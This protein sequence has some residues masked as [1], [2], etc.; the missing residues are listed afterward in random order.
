MSHHLSHIIPTRC[1]KLDSRVTIFIIKDMKKYLLIACIIFLTSNFASAQTSAEG[2]ILSRIAQLSSDNLRSY[3]DPLMTSLGVALGTGIFYTAR[4]H[5]AFG[6]D[7]GLRVMQVRIPSSARF[8][9][10]TV[11]ACSLANGG[12]DCYDILVENASTIFGPEEATVVPTSGNALAIP[13]VF[14][15]GLDVNNLPFVMPQINVGFPFGL[16]LGF[17]YLPLAMTFPL[18]REKNVSFIR[19]GAKL[20]FNKLPY[21]NRI[22][23]PM[24]LAIGGFYQIGHVQGDDQVATMN[25]ALWNLQILASKRIG[26]G[27]LLA[28]EPFLAG[29][30][31]GTSFNFRYD[32]QKVLPDTIGGIPTDSIIVIEPIDIDYYQQNRF[33]AIIGMSLYVG[34]IFFHYDYNAVTYRTHNLML[35]ITVR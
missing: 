33:R 22:N 20:G 17:G 10:A 11:V 16:E 24:D 31:E 6:F 3:A 13:P 35:G 2:S 23:L 30:I 4:S 15:G 18:D 27:W 21:L 26:T 8:F 19:L 25:M 14:P 34:P 29:G 7:F 1:L 5:D 9:N 32:F 12:L 28:I